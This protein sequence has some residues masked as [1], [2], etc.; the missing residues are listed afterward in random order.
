MSKET[1]REQLVA[2]KAEVERLAKLAEPTV[3][4]KLDAALTEVTK[5]QEK[6][7][8]AERTLSAELLRDIRDVPL[9]VVE[10]AN[11]SLAVCKSEEMAQQTADAHNEQRSSSHPDNEVRVLPLAEYVQQLEAAIQHMEFL[12]SEQKRHMKQHFPKAPAS[13]ESILAKA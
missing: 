8:A 5:W 10:C 4:E 7:H 13:P 12:H 9:Y 2:A 3:E 6:A 1:I 11:K